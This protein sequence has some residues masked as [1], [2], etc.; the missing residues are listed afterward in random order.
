MLPSGAWPR[1]SRWRSHSKSARD[2]SV[3]R[4]NPATITYPLESST[5]TWGRWGSFPNPVGPSPRSEDAGLE[6][7]KR[8]TRTPSHAAERR[9]LA[10]Q[11]GALL[12][13]SSWGRRSG[14]E[15]GT[16]FTL[17][18]AC[19]VG[20]AADGGRENPERGMRRRATELRGQSA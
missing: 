17:P 8:L 7:E 15:R 5:E 19:L 16:R 14:E 1:A 3:I 11:T 10:L 9:S 12:A 4:P 18:P 6:R 2:P 13:G 20:T